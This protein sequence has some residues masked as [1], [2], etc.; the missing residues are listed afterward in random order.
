MKEI[1]SP[2]IINFVLLKDRKN[3]HEQTIS[4]KIQTHF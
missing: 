2:E 3:K 1:A 4:I